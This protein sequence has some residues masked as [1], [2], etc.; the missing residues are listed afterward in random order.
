MGEHE[1]LGSEEI[2]S[3]EIFIVHGRDE[4]MKLAVANTLWTLD[5]DPIILHEK[6]DKGR[7]IIEKFEDYSN[8]SFATVLLSPDDIALSKDELFKLLQDDDTIN[9]IE[10]L[11][12]R[13]NSRARQNVIFELGFF[14]GKLGRDHVAV[15]HRETENFEM[16]SDYTGIV[17]IKYEKDGGWRY[18]LGRELRHCGYD[19]DLAKL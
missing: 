6:P 1:T 18:K 9:P 11:L 8:V 7:T 16:L 12:K 15:I 4:E 17:Y 10:E 19:V 5:L 14:V 3:N 13:A 2:S